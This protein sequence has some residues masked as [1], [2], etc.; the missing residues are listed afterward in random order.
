[1]R[2]FAASAAAEAPAAAKTAKP[3]AK[4]AAKKKPKKKPVA[5]R[6]AKPGRPAKKL[7]PE[8]KKKVQVRELKKGALLSEPKKLPEQPWVLYVSEN[9]KGTKIGP[10]SSLAA[11]MADLARSFKALSASELQV[12]QTQSCLSFFSFS[13]SPLL[14]FFRSVW[15]VVPD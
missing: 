9:A 12:R 4:T 5:K 6:A 14:S 3:K 15:R 8:E 10:D 13:L 7:T 1:M 2:G 11:T